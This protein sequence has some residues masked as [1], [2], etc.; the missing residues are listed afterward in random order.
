MAPSGLLELRDRMYP[1]SALQDCAWLLCRVNRSQPLVLSG[2][3]S[4]CSSSDLSAVL[5]FIFHSFE[6]HLLSTFHAPSNWLGAKST[7]GIL[8]HAPCP[9]SPQEYTYSVSRTWPDPS[10]SS[11]LELHVVTPTLTCECLFWSFF[12]CS[13]E[14]SVIELNNP[15]YLAVP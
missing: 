10:L 12:F 7:A 11:I 3:P 15:S 4:H 8:L 9:H 14:A 6:K 1:S 2:A 13:E 5:V